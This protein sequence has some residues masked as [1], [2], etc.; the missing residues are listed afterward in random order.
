[1][2]E[3]V[4]PCFT[5]TDEPQASKFHSLKQPRRLEQLELDGQVLLRVLTEVVNELDGLGGELVDVVVELRVVDEL[6]GCPL[7]GL[8]LAHEVVRGAHGRV[9]VVV[10]RLVVDEA[11][12]AALA[13]VDLAGDV[14]ELRGELVELVDKLVAG[15]GQR[16]DAARL[17]ALLEQLPV[18]HLLAERGSRRD[19]DDLVAPQEARRA[20]LGLRVVAD[21]FVGGPAVD[22]ALDG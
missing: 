18:T 2:N 9:Q 8:N 10:E 14:G 17:R 15:L 13:L 21:E 12:D 1:M 22:L 6:A 7:A 5:T 16:L 19:V 11:T 20:E 4:E 3:T